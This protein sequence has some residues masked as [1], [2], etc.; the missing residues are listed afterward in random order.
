MKKVCCA[1][2]FRKKEAKLSLGSFLQGFSGGLFVTPQIPLKALV[3]RLVNRFV[4][5]N[6]ADC[7]FQETFSAKNAI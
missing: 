1:D 6:S 2:F 7:Y 5:S 3:R 4:Q